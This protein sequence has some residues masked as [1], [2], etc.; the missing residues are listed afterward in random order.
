MKKIL[1]NF[2][3]NFTIA[4]MMIMISASAYAGSVGLVAPESAEKLGWLSG[5]MAIVLQVAKSDLLGGIFAKVD[6]AY[7]PAVIL[8]LGQLGA[9]VE[10]VNSGIPLKTAAIQW[11]L[12]SGNAMA[13]YAVIIKPF[14]KKKPVPSGNNESPAPAVAAK[15]K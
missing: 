14:T 4:L 11:L 2:S 3:L 9:L 12:A 15:K 5:V 13:L 6:K 1:A 8:L 10:S 7:Q